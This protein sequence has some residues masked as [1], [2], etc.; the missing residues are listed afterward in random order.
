MGNVSRFTQTVEK[1]TRV[2]DV[3]PAVVGNPE[4]GTYGA[5]TWRITSG[6]EHP[7]RSE[8]RK[9]KLEAEDSTAEIYS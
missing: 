1:G 2:G 8:A 9:Q 3:S 6:F 7:T 4:E 5:H